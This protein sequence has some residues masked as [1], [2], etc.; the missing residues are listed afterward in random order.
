M[1]SHRSI[2]Q[3]EYALNHDGDARAKQGRK[4]TLFIHKSIE[5]HPIAR[6]YV[7][8]KRAHETDWEKED[9]LYDYFSG[10]PAD[11]E[12]LATSIVEAR[13]LQIRNNIISFA[14]IVAEVKKECYLKIDRTTLLRA[15][16]RIE[17]HVLPK[18][19][20]RPLL[21]SEEMKK[22]LCDRIEY[23]RL[24]IGS[25]RLD[26]IRHE[27]IALA[28]EKGILDFKASKSWSRLYLNGRG[29][30]VFN[31]HKTKEV[32]RSLKCQPEFGLTPSSFS[33][34]FLTLF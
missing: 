33:I 16:S 5:T 3:L 27:A 15:V 1:N 29:A 12:V 17:N 28:Q 11:I 13:R 2:I 34:L 32:V 10:T 25:I 23:R 6:A 7:A 31:P 8:L 14:T 19:P 22:M 26:D 20:S 18:S 4:G 24:K 9:C 30:K 21:F